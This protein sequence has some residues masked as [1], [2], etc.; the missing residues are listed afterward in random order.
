MRAGVINSMRGK[1]LVGCSSCSDQLY[2]AIKD[3]RVQAKLPR[4][5]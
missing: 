3:S 1:S 2:P 4:K 5:A